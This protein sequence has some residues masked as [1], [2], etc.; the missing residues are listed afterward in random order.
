[1][2]YK[3]RFVREQQIL[4]SNATDN[5]IL[6]IKNL[7]L[8]SPNSLSTI[9]NMILA[10]NISVHLLVKY[11]SRKREKPNFSLASLF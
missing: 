11:R 8:H 2:R 1:M 4:K 5:V 3:E 6:C 9:K 10:G 7:L